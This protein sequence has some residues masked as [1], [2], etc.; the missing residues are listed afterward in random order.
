MSNDFYE[1]R[2]YQ[3]EPGRMP[4]MASRWQG[5]L[6]TLFNRHGV[7]ALGAWQAVTGPALPLFVYLMHWPELATRQRAWAGFYGD[8]E[9]AD[10]RERTNA[11]SELVERYDL[12]FLQGISH[13]TQPG[14]AQPY[15]EMRLVNIAIGQSAAAR[16][17][18]HETLA[19]EIAKR[20]G[21][22][23]A[24]L[25]HMTGLDLPAI[26]LF[27]AWPDATHALAANPLF[28]EQPLNRATHYQLKQI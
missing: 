8:P 9:W 4:D 22:L 25:E 14:D 20:G 7:S 15:L 21:N 10:V 18:V 1:L 19:P 24:A 26:A 12:N 13:W 17:R 28:E 23:V 27:V 16:A 5:G 2:L 11:G 6:A 3:V